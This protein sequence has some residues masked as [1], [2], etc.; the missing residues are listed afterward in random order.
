MMR[1]TA[2]VIFGIGL[3]ATFLTLAKSAPLSSA[4]SFVHS[5]NSGS[6][7]VS[8]GRDIAPLDV[9]DRTAV[10]QF[11]HNNFLPDLAIGFT[12]DVTTG[13][14]GTTSDAFKDRVLQRINYYRVLA[15]V[16]GNIIW[17]PTFSDKAQAAAILVSANG[18][19]S[20]SPP[21]SWNFYTAKGGD[22][23]SRSLLALGT[24]GA[25]AI[26]GYIEDPGASNAGVGHRNWL[27]DWTLKA[28]GT[29][30]VPASNGKSAANALYVDDP[31]AFGPV[32][33]PRDHFVAWPNAGYTPYPGI[34]TR[35]SFALAG[36]D[37]TPAVVTAT[38]DG[39]PVTV[40]I[41]YRLWDGYIG[42]VVFNLVRNSI[43][44]T[45]TTLK[46]ADLN[47]PIHIKISNAL[48]SGQ[49]TNYD[50]TVVPIDPASTTPPPPPTV[51]V[52]D[53]VTGRVDQGI[54]VPVNAPDAFNFDATGLP[55]GVTIDSQTGV[56]S[57]TP[58]APGVY[59]VSI[60]ASN[61][62]A[63]TV[64]TTIVVQSPPLTNST[65]RLTN[66]ST[67]SLVGTGDD[68]QIA[69]FIIG[70]TS[71]KKVL[72]RA[73]GPALSQYG[74]TGVL[75]DPMLEL[76]QNNVEAALA[77]ND[78]WDASQ[79]RSLFQTLGVDNWQPGSKDAALLTTLDPGGYTAKVSGKNAT[80][81]VA[82]IE[83][84]EVD[85]DNT[86]SKLINISTRSKVGTGGNIQ[87]AGFIISGTEPKTVVIRA[88]GPG[89]AQYGVPGVVQDPV[90]GLYQGETKILENDNWDAS[91]APDFQAVK[92]FPW[93]AG[94]K[95]AA[96]VITLQPGGYTAQVSGKN[97]TTGVA[98]IE[99]FEE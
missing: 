14:P 35:W 66:I 31:G 50:Y 72:I 90:L 61:G 73:S 38:A 7:F 6:G 39:Q 75:A 92:A 58:T 65:A 87:I 63:V 78:D 12:G 16:S 30:D 80:T 52:P 26:D 32:S 70:G 36:A 60:T 53:Q 77:Q 43:T 37:F 62:T 25:A 89:L 91:V 29:G 41:E 44:L 45:G 69:G 19:L 46:T 1:I 23:A 48:V 96:I 5:Q 17:D 57:G 18:Q 21:T 4:P 94:S 49:S 2:Q 11:Y 71:P 86:A 56:I 74:L 15:G 54:D 64:N 27:F 34:F 68:V 51:T 95:D 76:H 84:Y 55:D 22:A 40:N 98:L 10:I 8:V 82:L 67:R 33:V 79:L 42:L 99:V 93:T 20:H 83:V 88:S 85:T 59:A 13:T 97:G 24:N 47:K 28:V 3:S 81:G 9:W